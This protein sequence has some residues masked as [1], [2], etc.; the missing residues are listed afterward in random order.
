MF[1]PKHVANARHRKAKPMSDF[2]NKTLLMVR[3]LLP[4]VLLF[5]IAQFAIRLTLAIYSHASLTTVADWLLPFAT[6]FLFDVSVVLMALPVLLVFPTL[7]P[8]SWAGGRLDRSVAF[9]AFAILAFLMIF[10]GI[11]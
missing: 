8:K 11:S 9:G 6:G 4:Y 7:L 3:R 5:L 1:Q 10:Q 2:Y